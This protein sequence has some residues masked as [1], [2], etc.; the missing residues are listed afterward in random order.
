[1]DSRISYKRAAPSQHGQNSGCFAPKQVTP[2]APSSLKRSSADGED[3]K[4]SS[5]TTEHH[6]SLPLTGLHR[7]T[8]SDTFA[9]QHTI[10]KLTVSLN[11]LTGRFATHSLK[12]ATAISLSGLLSLI[13]FS[14]P[15][16]SPQRNLLVTLHTTW[17]TASSPS[18]RSTSPKPRF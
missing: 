2:L 14:G 4:K 11:V 5:P 8:T 12:S 6:S 17:H 10:L 18:F 15:I 7:R 9:F 1:M 13:T 3:S 16:A